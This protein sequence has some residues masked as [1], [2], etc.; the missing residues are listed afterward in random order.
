MNSIG[1]LFLGELHLIPH[2]LPIAAALARRADA[3]V[4]T[5]HVATSVHEDILNEAVAKMGIDVTIRRVRGF[6]QAAAGSRETPPLPSK[7][8]VLALNARRFLKHD[9]VVVAE[10]T[11]L[12]LPKIARRLGI[13][14]RTRFVYNEHGA[15]PHA[16]FADPRNREA[17][18]I[19][20]PSEGMA[21][22]VR[23]SGHDDAPIHV[24]G[25]IKPDYVRALVTAAAMPV[26]AEAR[27][28][29]VYVPHWKRDKSS[30][31]GMGEAVMAWFAAQDR[32]NLIVAPH[33]RLP[34]FDPEFDRRVTPYRDRPNIVVDAT[35]YRLIDQTYTG[36]ADL[37]LGD[38]SSQVVEF[39]AVKPRPVIFLN[40]DRH[41][42]A[43]DSR[44][45][46]WSM[47]DVIENVAALPGA[48]DAA[49]GRLA[50]Y[51]PVQRAYVERMMGVDDGRASDRAADVVMSLMRQDSGRRS[52]NR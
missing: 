46:H 50:A 16:N 8:L 17:A 25:Y 1:F 12:W 44:F 10:R 5:L 21:G 22:R 30:W 35:S 11:S 36:N 51:E 7:P 15:A 3:P 31:W 24:V 34:K 42:W 40:P 38:G 6:R 20:M 32:Y 19:L 23:A 28:V 27:P 18:A 49:P 13:G 43:E 37:Y 9:V 48:L 52:G 29:V 33:V 4:I 2:L 45:S 14:R 26:F 41:P 47:G 39:A